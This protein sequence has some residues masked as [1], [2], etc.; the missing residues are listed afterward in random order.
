MQ[1]KSYHEGCP[2]PRSGLRLLRVLYYGYDKKTHIGEMIVASHVADEFLDIFL[3]L[4]QNKYEFNKIQ[5]I[6]AYDGDDDASIADD[7]T[8]C[9]NHRVV[10]GTTHLSKHSYGIAIDIN[11]LPNPY[12][13]WVDGERNVSP[14]E[15]EPYADRERDFAHKITHD[16]L[17]YRLFHAYGYKWGGDWNS[18]KDYQHFQKE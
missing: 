17:C 7:N 4:Y 5:R 18:E 2:V 15:A 12:V 1:G 16:D 3:E 13:H 8:S 9:F 10:E 11:P 6:D 14:P